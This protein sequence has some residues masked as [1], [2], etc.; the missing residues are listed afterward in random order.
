MSATN[1]TEPGGHPGVPQAEHDA[2]VA[3]ARADGHAA[4]VTE[5]RTAGVAAEQERFA[6]ILNSDAGKANLPVA[7]ALAL[8]GSTADQAKAVLAVTP[9]G[10]GLA[11]QMSGVPD[12]ELGTGARPPQGAAGASLAA[13]MAKRFGASAQS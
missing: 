3:A 8:T 12:P 9:K 2:A 10:A 5:G 13:K 7:V 4:G 6:A 11:Q 1:P